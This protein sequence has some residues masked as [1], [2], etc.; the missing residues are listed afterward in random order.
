MKKIAIYLVIAVLL[1]MGLMVGCQGAVGPAGV[2]GPAGIAGPT[3]AAGPAG[4][5]GLQFTF[6]SP[7]FV[8]RGVI[9]IKYSPYSGKD[10]KGSPPLNWSNAPKT[11]KSFVI[12]VADLNVPWATLKVPAGTF[13]GDLLA[14]WMVFD[15][16]VSVTSLAEGVSPG[17]A[18]GEK[19]PKGAKEL[20]NDCARFGGDYTKYGMGYV[21][22]M[23]PKGDY[24]HTY[25][26]TIYAVN[27]ETLPGLT[28]G[29]LEK[30]GAGYGDLTKAIAGKSLAS[31]TITGYFCLPK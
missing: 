17:K 12:V 31:A 23:P 18:L 9:P 14:H 2:P 3:G 1:L 4:P 13:P 11:T 24:S 20:Y 5:P 22:P 16:P 25:I 15:I 10:Y 7:A 28:P 21:G 8:D 29:T 19:L 26:F 27:V 30:P 6:L